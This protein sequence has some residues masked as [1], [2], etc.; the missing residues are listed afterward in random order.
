M[1]YIML[2]LYIIILYTDYKFST[3]SLFIWLNISWVSAIFMSSNF[4]TPH[5]LLSS[6]FI[7]YISLQMHPLVLE[8]ILFI[9][10]W[11]NQFAKIALFILFPL[12]QPRSKSHKL[13]SNSICC[14]YLL[15]FPVHSYVKMSIPTCNLSERTWVKEHSQNKD[16]LS[17]NNIKKAKERHSNKMENK[18]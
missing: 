12:T 3:F 10:I 13:A 9:E 17:T 8:I 5:Y 1:Y 15:L 18:C 4:E 14:F 11:E 6:S 7:E 16:K 2:Q